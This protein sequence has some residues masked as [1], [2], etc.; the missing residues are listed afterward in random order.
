MGSDF[1]VLHSFGKKMG[2]GAGFL[3]DAL[4]A[5]EDSPTSETNLP[6]H[7]LSLQSTVLPASVPRAGWPCYL[8]QLPVHSLSIRESEGGLPTRRCR[9]G[10]LHFS[11]RRVT[12]LRRKLWEPRKGLS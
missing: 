7:F 3:G 6:L 5:A 1:K 2:G 11:L 9:T 10:V 8:S 4:I 12:A